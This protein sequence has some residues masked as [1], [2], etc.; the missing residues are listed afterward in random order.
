MCCC[1][2]ASCFQSGSQLK[3]EFNKYSVAMDLPEG[4]ALRSSLQECQE[5]LASSLLDAF[6]GLT[7]HM[8]FEKLSAENASSHVGVVLSEMFW[9]YICKS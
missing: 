2:H 3:G 7:C 4:H 9:V 8:S 6:L 1:H 5:K